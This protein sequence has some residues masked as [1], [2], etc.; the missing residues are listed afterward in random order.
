VGVA[1]AVPAL[2]VVV[3]G[4]VVVV[5]PPLPPPQ[6]ANAPITSDKINSRHNTFL[7]FILFLLIFFTCH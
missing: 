2:L 1:A 3:L 6:A 7:T 4:V 5:P